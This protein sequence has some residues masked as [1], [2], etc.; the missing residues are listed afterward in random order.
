M[1]MTE[2]GSEGG[3]LTATEATEGNQ[4]QV[5]QTEGQW[6]GDGFGDL[7]KTKGWDS[8]DSVMKSYT[9]LEKSMGNRVKIPDGNSSQEEVSAFYQKIGVPPNADGYELT[10]MPEGVPRDEGMESTIMAA[11]HETGGSQ[12]VVHAMFKAY[13]DGIATAMAQERE[14]TKSTLQ[15][16]WKQDYEANL[17]I[18]QRACRELFGEEAVQFLESSG[19]GNNLI[20]TR[21]FHELGKKM[22]PDT[23]I[24][25]NTG[26]EVEAGYVPAYPKSPEQYASDTS[27]EG[28]KARAWFTARGHMY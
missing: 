12:Q 10:D 14:T 20:L 4:E 26:P 23:A 17:E 27:P 6:Y 21:G 3:L 24:Q 16:D 22:L 11:A 2:Q 9:E 13:Y 5:T 18:S 1:T 28:V 7:V 25:G 8:A 15:G 19:L